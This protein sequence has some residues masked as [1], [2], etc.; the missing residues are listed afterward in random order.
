MNVQQ[1]FPISL[2]GYNDSY[3]YGNDEKNT[4]SGKQNLEQQVTVEVPEE[5]EPMTNVRQRNVRLKTKFSQIKFTWRM[6]RWHILYFLV[7]FSSFYATFHY[8]F[9]NKHKTEILAA[10][11]FCDDW[12]QLAFFL[13]IYLSFS[14]K[15]VSDVSSVSIIVQNSLI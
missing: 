12:K 15:K 14:V 10:L 8:A 1:S 5:E 13:G 9:D 6:I 11:T 7:I 2:E 3:A 4:Y